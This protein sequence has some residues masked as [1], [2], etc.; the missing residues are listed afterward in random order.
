VPPLLVELGSD[1][2]LFAGWCAVW[3]A[4]H[5]ADRPHDPPR[6]ATEHVG[7][8]RGLVAPGGSRDGTHRAALVDGTVVGALR[9][10]LPLRDNAAVAFT[11][12]QIRLASPERAQHA[13]THALREHRG[14]RLGARMKAAVLRRLV[15]TFP[16]VRLI[17]TYNSEGNLPMVAV[18]EALGFRPAGHLS[19]WSSAL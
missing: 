5:R 7:L 10:I 6:P 9:L 12:L 13:G 19:T 17:S 15:A 8:G 14:H 4:A 3:T 18:N 11:D 16:A 2:D 1:D